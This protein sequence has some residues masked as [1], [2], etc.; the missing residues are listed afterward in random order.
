MYTKNQKKTTSHLTPLPLLFNLLHQPFRANRNERMILHSYSLT[1]DINVCPTLY[2]LSIRDQKKKEM[3]LIFPLF[4]QL[5]LPHSVSSHPPPLL[6]CARKKR[7]N[8]PLDFRSL[9]VTKPS[10]TTMVKKKKKLERYDLTNISVAKS[11]SNNTWGDCSS[12]DIL[13]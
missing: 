4:R 6:F 5:I 2:T 9:P 8:T 1:L 13:F 12:R 11:S 7:V 10:G 3:N